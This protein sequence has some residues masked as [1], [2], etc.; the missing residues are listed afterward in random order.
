M[1]SDERPDPVPIPRVL[2]GPLLSFAGEA[3]DKALHDEDRAEER[4]FIERV[5]SD[6]DEIYG[7]Y[8]GSR[9]LNR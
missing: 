1:S 5:I 7:L 6:L 3:A 2:L 8:D 4:G 9:E